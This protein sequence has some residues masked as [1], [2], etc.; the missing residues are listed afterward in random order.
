MTCSR[1]ILKNRNVTGGGFSCKIQLETPLRCKL[2]EKIAS[3][4]MAL[5][6]GVYLENVA[7]LFMRVVM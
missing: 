7:C 3:C 5:T 4:D 2:R 6:G 1:I